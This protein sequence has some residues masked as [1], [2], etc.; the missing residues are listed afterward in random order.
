MSDLWE[1][2]NSRKAKAREE[3]TEQPFLLL[4]AY[5]QRSAKR[6]GCSLGYR[7][8][9]PGRELTQPRKHLLAEPCILLN[10]E[11]MSDVSLSMSRSRRL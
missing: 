10:F 5:M 2:N 9:E 8:A 3:E 11:M 4:A 6:R 1:S 7:Q